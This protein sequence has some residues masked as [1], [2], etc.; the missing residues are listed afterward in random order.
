MRAQVQGPDVSTTNRADGILFLHLRR[1]TNGIVLL[2]SNVRPGRLKPQASRGD[3]EFETASAGDAGDAGDAG[4]LDRGLIQDPLVQRFEYEDPESPGRI[5][6]KIV[7]RPSA[8]FFIR[9]PNREAAKTIRFYRKPRQEPGRLAP[10]A[11]RELISEVILPGKE[12]KAP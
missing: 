11:A 2:D 7:E 8:E 3:I 12:A 5:K 9:V 4:I 10:Q 6:V 1:D